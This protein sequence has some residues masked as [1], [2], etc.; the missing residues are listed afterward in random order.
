MGVD[1]PVDQSAQNKST[2]P[3]KLSKAESKT[4]LTRLHALVPRR[5]L[6]SSCR[7]AR[8]A[9]R[10]CTACTPGQR[11]RVWDAGEIHEGEVTDVEVGLDVYSTGVTILYDDEP[12]TCNERL[13]NFEWELI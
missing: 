3:A 1:L 2:K 9:A 11:V 5:S 13:G 6:C 4:M 7:T 12:G 8:G 10:G